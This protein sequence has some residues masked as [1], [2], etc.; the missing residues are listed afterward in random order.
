MPFI[1]PKRGSS[2]APAPTGGPHEPKSPSPLAFPPP[3]V[4]T[5]ADN[6]RSDRAGL[7]LRSPNSPLAPRPVRLDLIP[8]SPVLPSRPPKS[9]VTPQSVRFAEKESVVS[10]E[11]RLSPVGDPDDRESFD[12]REN[13]LTALPAG[14]PKLSSQSSRPSSI[15]GIGDM[16][17][18]RSLRGA[19]FGMEG[20]SAGSRSSWNSSTFGGSGRSSPWR[21][22]AERAERKHMERILREEKEEREKELLEAEAKA[23][24]AAEKMES[25]FL[26]E[27]MARLE[28][29]EAM[30]RKRIQ[31]RVKKLQSTLEDLKR[32]Q[33]EEDRRQKEREK[34][35]R[36]EDERFEREWQDLVSHGRSGSVDVMAKS[37]SRGSQKQD[38]YVAP[39]PAPRAKDEIIETWLRGYHHASAS[40]PPAA[41]LGREK[42]SWEGE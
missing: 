17:G 13:L 23:H 16:D 4:I 35:E 18:L 8:S 27:E 21:E 25:H 12:Y 32:I 33:D 28:E 15:L 34:E 5:P 30:R 1:K 22:R 29:K 36:E 19:L 10:L 7:S 31:D 24:R 41:A 40:A 2:A 14:T 6:G 11:Q 9:P 26:R 20:A 42:Y 39:R 3:K 38:S 37:K